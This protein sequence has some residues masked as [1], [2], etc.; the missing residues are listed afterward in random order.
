MV[1]LKPLKTDKDVAFKCNADDLQHTSHENLDDLK[2]IVDFQD[3]GEE[4]LGITK[5]TTDD[6]WLNKLVGNGTFIGETDDAT[7]NL[8][9][10]F[11][12]EENN[13]EDDIL[14]PKFK[15]KPFFQYPSF[16]PST[17]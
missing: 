4:N 10:R 9:G 5:N 17:P 7:S 8:G 6:P 12:H 16:D 13:P 11:Y 3:E 15:A 2:D 14:D 1:C